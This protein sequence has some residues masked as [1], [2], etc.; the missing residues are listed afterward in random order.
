M[1]KTLFPAF[2]D[3]DGNVLWPAVF[4]MSLATGILAISMVIL[5]V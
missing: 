4:G 2:R 1:K 5:F 3:D